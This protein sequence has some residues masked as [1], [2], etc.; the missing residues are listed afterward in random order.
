MIHSMT[1]YGSAEGEFDGVRYVVEIK[2]VNQ[3]YL[4]T[5]IK[6]PDAAA[7][8]EKDIDDLIRHRLARGAVNYTLSLKNVSADYLFDID[9][10]ALEGYLRRLDS[11][12][13]SA[14]VSYPVEMGNLLNLPGI[15]QPVSPDEATARRVRQKIL[16]ISTQAMEQLEKMRSSEGQTLAEDLRQHCEGIRGD[17]KKIA[18]Q[19]EKV[20]EEYHRKL[21]KRA[22]SLLAEAKLNLDES[23]LAREVAVFAERSDIEEE[24][25]RLRSHL[26][27][28]EQTCRGD[29]QSGRRLD[30][31]SQELLREA[32]TIASKVSDAEIARWVVDMKCRIDR[33][34]EQ[35]QNI[36]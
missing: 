35:V 19:S 16:E 12:A 28:F 25:S 34:K 27:Q 15:I 13:S 36:E 22:D 30:F 14:G 18:G 23:I 33:I 6:L 1:G 31:I 29:G 26:E 32:N 20:L 7:F 21:K 8:L 10:R 24:L 5:S 4:K 11:V 2:T 3:R 17:L 9:D